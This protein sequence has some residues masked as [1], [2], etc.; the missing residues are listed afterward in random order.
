MQTEKQ[1]G[2]FSA[3]KYPNTYQYVRQRI[4]R[5]RKHRKCGHNVLT[6]GGCGKYKYQCMFCDKDLCTFQTIKSKACCSDEE[7]IAICKVTKD[8]L[9]LD[10]NNWVRHYAL[11]ANA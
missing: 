5:D 6:L 3:E 8:L 7:I 9:H 10:D 2:H 4:V 1:V 11:S